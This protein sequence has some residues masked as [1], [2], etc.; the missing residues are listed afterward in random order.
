MPYKSLQAV[1]RFQMDWDFSIA[2]TC[3]VIEHWKGE[4]EKITFTNS[5]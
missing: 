5:K 4:R 2:K 3:A 1:K